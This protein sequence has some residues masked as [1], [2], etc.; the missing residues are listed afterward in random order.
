MTIDDERPRDGYTTYQRAAAYYDCHPNFL[1][2]QARLGKLPT[3]KLGRG[4]RVRWDDLDKLLR[5][6]NHPAA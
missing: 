6:G 1:R 5:R 3:Y 4:V 2:K